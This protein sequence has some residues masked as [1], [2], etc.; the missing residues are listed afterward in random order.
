[1][2]PSELHVE[3]LGRKHEHAY[4]R[5]PLNIGMRTVSAGYRGEEVGLIYTGG[6]TRDTM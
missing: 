4:V 1:M 3:K 6:D 2:C 5:P